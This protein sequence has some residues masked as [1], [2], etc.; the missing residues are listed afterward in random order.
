MLSKETLLPLQKGKNLL[1][2][3]AGVDS[4]ALFFLLMKQNISF[5]LAIVNY[6]MRAQADEEVAHAQALAKQYNKQ[7]FVLEKE[8]PHKNFEAQARTLRYDFFKQRIAAH[9]Y[10]QLITAHQLDDR[11]EWFLMQFTKGAGLHELT[12]MRSIESRDT[13]TL[14]RPL[15]ETKKSDL[16]AY[17]HQHNIHYFEDESNQDESYRRNYFRH[18]VTAP[19]LEQFEQGIS[20]SLKYLQ[21]DDAILYQETPH[22]VIDEL[23]YFKTT[24]TRRLD[25]IVVDKI[26]KELGFLMR[27][28][29]KEQ[30]KV[31]DE[32]LVGRRFVV[33]FHKQY[34]FIA[35][36]VQVTMDKVFKEQ[37]RKLKIP[38]K[39]RGYLFENSNASPCIFSL[40]QETV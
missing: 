38:S 9:H 28:G 2:F 30:L 4:S 15:L 3:S 25:I 21:E 29:D 22:E 7:C 6:K 23:Y 18:N 39:L 17:L 27:Q 20:N 14:I 8:L 5:D 19:L 35:P 32:H 37:C 11:L 36:Y 13:Y 33:A 26:L 10:T 31:H 34:C 40:L 24:A 12:G 16:L 1:A